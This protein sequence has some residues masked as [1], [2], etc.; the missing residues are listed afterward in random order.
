MNL[1]EKNS[2]INKSFIK[3]DT[4]STVQISMFDG[5]TIEIQENSLVQISVQKDGSVEAGVLPVRYLFQ[6]IPKPKRFL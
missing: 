6:A 5:S 4:E 3:T 2:I 1:S